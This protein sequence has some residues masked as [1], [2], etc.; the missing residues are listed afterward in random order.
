MSLKGSLK[1]LERE[2]F[3]ESLKERLEKSLKESINKLKRGLLKALKEHSIGERGVGAMP[4]SPTFEM[5][6]MCM[7]TF[8]IISAKCSTPLIPWLYQSAV[9]CVDGLCLCSCLVSCVS[10]GNISQLNSRGHFSL[11]DLH[12]GYF[13]RDTLRFIPRSEHRQGPGG[14][15]CAHWALLTVAQINYLICNRQ[16]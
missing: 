1:R 8:D 5:Q 14:A 2:S 4:C 16:L 3:R 15:H 12:C 11:T 6:K 10:V 9:I 13:W 7:K